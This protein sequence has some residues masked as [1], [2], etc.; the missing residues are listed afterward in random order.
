MTL[1]ASIK[2]HIYLSIQA[3]STTEWIHALSNP[4][5]YLERLIPSPAQMASFTACGSKGDIT[6]PPT[7]TLCFLLY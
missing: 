2:V 5:K 3:T 4:R 1:M 6:I 7:V